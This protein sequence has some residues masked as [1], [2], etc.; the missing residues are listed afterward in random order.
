MKKERNEIFVF[1]NATSE[2][3]LEKLAKTLN[4]HKYYVRK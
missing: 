3:L 2:N 4:K 1:N